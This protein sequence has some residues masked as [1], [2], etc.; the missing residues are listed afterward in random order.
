MSEPM[1]PLVSLDLAAGLDAAVD[2]ELV[3]RT[4]AAVLAQCRPPDLPPLC[5]VTVR[6]TDD[7]ELHTLNH[8]YRQ[9]DAPTDVLSFA[10]TEAAGA[11]TPAFVTPPELPTYLGDIVI[12][13]ERVQ[14]Q[15]AAYGHS[16]ARE[17]AYLVAHGTLHLLGF[18]H[19]TSAADAAL[20]RQHE[21]AVMTQIGLPRP[22]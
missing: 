13:Y 21:E 10:T 11:A 4:V 15:A 14:A 1:P 9:I 22:S 8:T 5:E 19:E 6:L 7:A 16:I 2:R 18:D 3:A 12:S 20:M 17:L